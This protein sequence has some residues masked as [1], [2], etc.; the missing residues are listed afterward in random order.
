MAS[1]E[2]M[3]PII[4]GAAVVAAMASIA[5]SALAVD[6]LYVRVSEFAK[7]LDAEQSQYVLQLKKDIRQVRQLLEDN[8]DDQYLED[9][10]ADLIDTL[11]EIRPDD[12]LCDEPE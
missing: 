6:H 9:D 2:S 3:N 11:C 12:R 1:D 5:G 4:K 7:Y 8:P 10:L